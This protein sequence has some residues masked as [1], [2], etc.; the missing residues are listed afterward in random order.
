MRQRR[1]ITIE[2]WDSSLAYYN[3]TFPKPFIKLGK[4]SHEP[5]PDLIQQVL[6]IDYDLD[7]DEELAEILGDDVDKES[8]AS[9]GYEMS[10]EFDS[11]C[12]EEGFIVDDDEFSDEE[13]NQDAKERRERI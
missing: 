6:G 1:V 11:E 3:Y 8:D 12:L 9:E 5:L 7:S 4:T 2:I 10:D 13:L